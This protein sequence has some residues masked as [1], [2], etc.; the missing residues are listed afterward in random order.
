MA[1]PQNTTAGTSVT[2][3]LAVS[4][5]SG[6]NIG[7][8]RQWIQQ[9]QMTH[10]RPPSKQLIEAFLQAQI[11]ASI[12]RRQRERELEQRQQQLAMQEKQ[13]GFQERTTTLAEKTERSSEAMAKKRYQ[14]DLERMAREEEAA[15]WKGVGQIAGLG[16]AA[17]P[18]IFGK[19][20]LGGG[21]M[22]LFKSDKTPAPT[23]PTSGSGVVSNAMESIGSGMG[24]WGAG[25]PTNDWSGGYGS[26]PRD[27][28]EAD[29]GGGGGYTGTPQRWD[30]WENDPTFGGEWGDGGS[31]WGVSDAFSDNW[32]G[33]A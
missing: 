33:L 28:I 9:Y 31:D 8:L 16:I 15:S 6:V 11:Q 14:M 4:E 25:Y 29:Y 23:T 3:N 19:D 7:A 2:G 21:L 27:P 26:Y 17:A 30:Q 32:G 5:G 24:D 12:E 1:Y 10:G 18:L 13:L 20:A 22:S